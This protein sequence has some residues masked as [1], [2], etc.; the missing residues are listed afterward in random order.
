ML[1][2]VDGDKRSTCNGIPRGEY[3]A[4]HF[5]VCQFSQ[6]CTTILTKPSDFGRVG[7]RIIRVVIQVR[8]SMSYM[9]RLI[10]TLQSWGVVNT[11]E[12]LAIEFY[13][14]GS[15]LLRTRKGSKLSA[16]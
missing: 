14:G 4:H 9:H 16:T 13:E 8:R 11:C 15:K 2:V 12:L 6:T 1:R 5:N 7:R 10:W 3:K